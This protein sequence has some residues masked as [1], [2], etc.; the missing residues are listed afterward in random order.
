M[1][2]ETQD[3]KKG[4]TKKIVLV[5]VLI[6]SLCCIISFVAVLVTDTNEPDATAE[7][8][9]PEPTAE[10][11]SEPTLERPLPACQSFIDILH[12]LSGHLTDH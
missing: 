12:F 11:I 1:S 10:S 5:V 2:T 4:N 3:K 7:V 8:I 6:L 9:E